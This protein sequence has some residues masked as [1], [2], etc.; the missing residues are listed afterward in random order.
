MEQE[1]VLNKHMIL[2]SD[3]SVQL[4]GRLLDASSKNELHHETLSALLAMTLLGLQSY[5]SEQ[6]NMAA[7]DCLKHLTEVNQG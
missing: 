7:L 5:Q 6:T 2:G 4:Y 1:P 3:E